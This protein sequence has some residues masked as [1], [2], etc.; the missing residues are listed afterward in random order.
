MNETFTKIICYY[1]KFYYI[2][3]V[4]IQLHKSA[5]KPMVSLVNLKVFFNNHLTTFKIS[6]ERKKFGFIKIK[7][8][9]YQT[10]HVPLT[11][12]N[13]RKKRVA[14]NKFILWQ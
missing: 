14:K 10:M 11:S 2:L 6:T 7:Y 3:Y 5:T 8:I 4:V 13:L 12:L 1:D 9:L